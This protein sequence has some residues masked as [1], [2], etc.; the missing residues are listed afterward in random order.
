MERGASVIGDRDFEITKSLDIKN[1]DIT[2]NASESGSSDTDLIRTID[3]KQ[4]ARKFNL[5]FKQEPDFLRVINMGP[6]ER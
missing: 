6:N 2:K 5:N 4:G 3:L 1:P